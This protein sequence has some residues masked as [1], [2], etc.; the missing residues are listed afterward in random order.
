MKRNIV[1]LFF[2]L[3]TASG[4]AQPKKITHPLTPC[5]GTADAVAGI[6]TDHANPKYGSH[7]IKGS[8][9]EKAAM[10]KNLIAIEKLEEASRKDF[11]LS[12]C[13]ARVSFSG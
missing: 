10:T 7:S 5:N 1:F 11:T 3:A 13:A 4:I 9:T 8:V 12:G 6:Y 2:V